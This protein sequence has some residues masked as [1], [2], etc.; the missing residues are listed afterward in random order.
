[1]VMMRKALGLGLTGVGFGGGSLFIFSP[2]TR[3]DMFV[4]S[5]GAIR[6]TRTFLTGALVTAD[7]KWTNYMHPNPKVRN[8]DGVLVVSN[9]TQL[10]A[11]LQARKAARDATHA[12]SAKRLLWLCRANGGIYTKFGQHVASMNHVLPKVY[13]NTLAG[14]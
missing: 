8:D 7:Y 12:R 4:A 2:S 1:M 11:Q 3:E 5:N 9:E 13:T 6:F 14:T 10:R